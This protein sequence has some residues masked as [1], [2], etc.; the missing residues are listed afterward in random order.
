MNMFKNSVI[1]KFESV[2]FL[3]FNTFNINSNQ[4]FNFFFFFFWKVYAKRL[5]IDRT[6]KKLRSFFFLNFFSIKLNIHE[7]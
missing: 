2:K 7:S 3:F 4:Q 6:K 1:C 5:P